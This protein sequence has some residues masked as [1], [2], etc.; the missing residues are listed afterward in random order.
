MNINGGYGFLTVDIA[1][2]EFKNFAGPT[3]DYQYYT[4]AGE[5]NDF[6]ASV[7]AWDDAY[8][9]EVIEVGYTNTLSINDTGLFDYS[10][11]AIH[12]NNVGIRDLAASDDDTSFVLSIS[13]AFGTE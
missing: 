1:I 11:A 5:Y 13:K 6:Y 7:S 12:S 3:L 9:G 8:E 10:I 2:G 4:L